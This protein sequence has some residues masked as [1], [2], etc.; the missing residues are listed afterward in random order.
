MCPCAWAVLTCTLS[1]L[2]AGVGRGP[3]G[4]RGWSVGLYCLCSFAPNASNSSGILQT[5][6]RAASKIYGTE[7][8]REASWVKVVLIRNSENNFEREFVTLGDRRWQTG[9]HILMICLIQIKSMGIICL[10]RCWKGTGFSVSTRWLSAT[11]LHVGSQ[12]CTVEDF[13]RFTGQ[14]HVLPHVIHWK[15]SSDTALMFSKS[16]FKKDSS[17]FY[18]WIMPQGLSVY[19]I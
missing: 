12:T 4:R 1:A 19:V 7:E 5:Q 9:P 8:H 2:V 11:A 13:E 3:A 10:T 14:S 16:I 15:V 17:D 6:R 18:L